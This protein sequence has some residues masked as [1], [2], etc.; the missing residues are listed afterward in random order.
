MNTFST[1]ARAVTLVVSACLMTTAALAG[2]AVPTVKL[3]YRS[4]D[5]KGPA[6]AKLYQRINTAARLVCAPLDSAELSRHVEFKHCV[7]Q[8]VARAVAQINAKDLT[9]VHL[10]HIGNAAQL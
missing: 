5:L 3:R 6:A 10:A 4:A 7:D 2:P 1:A 9:A 8:S